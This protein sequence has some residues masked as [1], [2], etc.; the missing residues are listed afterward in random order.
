MTMIFLLLAMVFVPIIAGFTLGFIKDKYHY[1]T[2]MIISWGMV[3]VSATVAMAVYS[4]DEIAVN[5]SQVFGGIGF[6]TTGFSAVYIA[7]TAFLFA[8]SITAS[9]EYLA[10]HGGS[11]GLYFPSMLIT[12]SGCFG[13]FLAQDLM[14]LFI[15][16]EIMSFTSYIWVAYN[17]NDTSRDASKS[18]LCYGVF[19]G[20][21]MLFGIVLVYV[22]VGSLKISELA[23]LYADKG[24]EALTVVAAVLL[25]I[26][27]GAK[28]GAF[29]LHDW[30]PKAHTASPAP[31]SALLSGLLTKAGIYGIVIITLKIAFAVEGFAVA[32]LVLSIFNMLVGAVH[33]FTSSNL[34]RTLAFSS[35]SQ[36]GFI[37]FGISFSALLGEHST[38]AVMG[39]VLHM[40]NHSLIK[41]VLFNS[42]GVVYQN[43]HSL[44]L[45]ELRGYG[46][47]KP[48][49]KVTFGLAA[50]SIMGIPFFSGYVS[51]TL[52]HESVV[53]YMALHGGSAL[54]S[55]AEILF[56][57]SGGFTVAY[58]LKLFICLFVQK[59]EK[60][61]KKENYAT[62]KTMVLLSAVSG[63]LLIFGVFANQI[64]DKIAEF[65][66]EFFG[67]HHLEESISYLSL[68]NLKGAAISISIGLILYFVVA[69]KTVAKNGVYTDPLPEKISIEN[70][71]YKPFV[72][73]FVLVSA[74]VMRIFDNV[75]DIGI[76]ILNKVFL[77]A[78]KI[79]KN[80]FDGGKSKH[81]DA[82]NHTPHITYSLS[83]SLLLFGL[84]FIITVIYLL[85][86]EFKL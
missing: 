46:R 83:F 28:A 8:V 19:G 52:L 49:L 75:T 73:S 77:R 14:T 62:K 55:V 43:T 54:Y 12:L 31:A 15:F 32:L 53:E 60:E 20:I 45:N 56:L 26:G 5:L 25:F 40:I 63:L 22:Q 24:S 76:L 74:V 27:F 69:R 13:L 33:A 21:S 59:G 72:K 41:L 11:T 85:T 61:W 47:N 78:A 42:A 57:V 2:S 10:S 16:F 66:L 1:I 67:A 35:V 65:T 51:K 50:A 86:V 79:P 29:L 37:L 84:G 48:W 70:C 6:E 82:D 9:K 30:L 38:I 68:T 64:F 23:S 7:V 4:G 39:A 36:I 71:I 18:Y 81:Y 34:K 3:A 80:F 58:M 44:D 17:R